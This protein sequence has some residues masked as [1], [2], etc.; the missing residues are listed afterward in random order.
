MSAVRS[1]T[2]LSFVRY[3]PK[4]TKYVPA[5]VEMCKEFLNAA[6]DGD[7]S[8]VKRLLGERPERIT[9][10]NKRDAL[11]LAAGSVAAGSLETVR[12][13]LEEGGASIEDACH[14]FDGDSA[15]HRAA[16]VG[17]LATIQLLLRSYSS[18]GDEDHD[19]VDT[20]LVI[21]S[22]WGQLATVQ[23]VLEH[24]EADM[25]VTCADQ[26]TT[27]WDELGRHFIEDEVDTDDSDDD[28]WH[29]TN[30]DAAAVTAL[31]RVMVLKGDPPAGLT[32][33]LLP[34]HARVVHGGGRLRARLPAYLA[35]RQAL[36]YEHY[37]LIARL[38][39]LVHGYG[40]LTTTD[41]LWATGVGAARQRAARLRADDGAVAAPLRRS[42]RLRQRR[43]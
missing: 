43:E 21:A 2:H 8:D 42:A 18:V 34:E 35:R 24:G 26:G 5:S 15:I 36:L 25:T 41:E 7:L 39:A 30:F 32:A 16:E 20:A 33:R 11:L 13:L 29:N 38:L 37:V 4:Q 19:V 12:W 40:M 14:T 27:I 17:N 3:T 31:L 1:Q 6:A 23:W 9:E 10:T 28:E 22:Q